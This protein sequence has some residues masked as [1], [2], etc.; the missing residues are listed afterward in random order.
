MGSGFLNGRLDAGRAS[1]Y[2]V[3]MKSLAPRRAFSLIELLVVI[4][5]IAILAAIL[6]PSLNAAMDNARRA[7]C[8]N[9]VRQIATAFNS[10]IGEQK[11]RLP[12]RGS[13]ADGW[14]YW[15]RAADQLL[16]YLKNAVEVFDCPANTDP[17]QD[18]TTEISTFSG[19]Y[20]EYEMNGYICSY[21]A[22]NKCESR[23]SMNLITDASKV[24][25]TYDFP[26]T[27]GA[28]RRPHKNGVN[29]GY[30]DGHASW[31]PDSD[32]GPLGQSVDTTNTFYRR[33]HVIKE[34]CNGTQ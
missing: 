16:P 34:V 19:K 14:K 9:N 7:R 3:S 25:Y 30:L 13:E 27:P 4:A 21:G 12:Y 31:L 17:I 22:A 5:V 33:G 2:E 24:A 8:L 10:L 11:S 6:L 1:G 28:N 26:Y 20:T 29:V 23:R 18:A 15:G 32:M